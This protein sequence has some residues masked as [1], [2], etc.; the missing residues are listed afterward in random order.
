MLKLGD[1]D[2][3]VEYEDLAG[4]E[5]I[6]TKEPTST[7]QVQPTLFAPRMSTTLLIQHVLTP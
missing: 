7:A 2:D 5:E 4:D 1:W 3:E 6:I